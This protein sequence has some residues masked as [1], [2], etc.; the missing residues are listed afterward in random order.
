MLSSKMK[1]PS[2]S[3]IIVNFNGITD[4]RVCL[5]SVLV[6]RYPNFKIIVADNKSTIDEIGILSQEFRSRKI[7]WKRFRKN[8]GFAGANNKIMKNVTSKYIV[9]LN[10]DTIVDPL[11][12]QKLIQYIDNDSSTAVCQ[13]KIRY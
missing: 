6:T 2:V 10:N 7:V 4:T 1:Y 12:L 3:I 9:L 8:F 13:A 5:R 11:W